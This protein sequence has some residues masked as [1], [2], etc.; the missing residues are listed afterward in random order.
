MNKLLLCVF[1]LF[2]FFQ[3]AKS[4]PITSL[5]PEFKSI[6]FNN[7]IEYYT[8]TTGVLDFK[9]V[10]R[11][12]SWKLIKGNHPNF[13]ENPF[14]HWLRFSMNSQGEKQKT[15]TLLTK[16]LDSLQAYLSKG[17]SLVKI[18]PL[19][20]SHIALKNREY[21]SPYLTLTFE[22]QPKTDYT[23]WIR[24]RNLNYRLTASPFSLYEVSQA[25]NFLQNKGLFH[26][27]YIGGMGIMLLFSIVLTLLFR[28]LIYAYYFG[29]VLCSLSIM[30]L[31]NDYSFM[32]FDKLPTIVVTKDIYG[33]MAAMIPSLYVLFAEKYLKISPLNQPRLVVISKA[34]ILSQIVMLG[35][36]MLIKV[37]LFQMRAF[38]YPPMMALS[39][40]SILYVFYSLRSGYM[41]AWLFLLATTPV[42]VS[43]LLETASDWH[44]I[45]V[46]QIHDYYYYTTLFEMFALTLGLA[47]RFKLDFDQKRILQREILLTQ[48]T[49]QEKERASIASDLHDVIGAQLSAI[50]LNLDFLQVQ[51]F[52]QSN[53]DW[54]MP[55]YKILNLLSEN[56]STIAARMRSSSLEK[57]GLSVVLEDIYGHLNKPVFHFDF[58][59][60]QKR[61]DPYPERILYIVIVEALNNCVKYAQATVINVQVIKEEKLVTV[62]IEDDGVG[63]NLN[64]DTA[65]QGIANMK[66]RIKEHLNGEF[67]IDTQ[68]G[69]GTVIIIKAP[70]IEG[71]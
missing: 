53:K 28:D 37:P 60:M 14:P 15:L 56:V 46:Q 54:W 38:F 71:L 32:L 36:F 23:L 41:P 7:N 64:Q 18:F 45:P 25:R 6:S 13:G 51:Y 55:V 5:G 22:V 3:K 66:I 34:I 17:D 30:L 4:Q 69:K 59:G 39:V 65:G 26:S 63:F 12:H 50:R 35:F 42:S 40:I 47:Y 27:L 8:D 29:C 70:L 16:G 9:H 58:I 52:E 20:G 62:I 11:I 61:I 2:L 21:P 49:T 10:S 1:A 31:Y 24:I 44:S 67:S 57:L 43:V 33:I 48:I 68:P 19:N